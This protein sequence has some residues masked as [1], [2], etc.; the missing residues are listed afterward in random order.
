MITLYQNQ[1]RYK[2]RIVVYQEL[3]ESEKAAVDAAH[4][5]DGWV[6]FR[7]VAIKMEIVNVKRT[8]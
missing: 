4:D 5:S 7:T 8:S 3:Y 2:N 1:Y 6:Y